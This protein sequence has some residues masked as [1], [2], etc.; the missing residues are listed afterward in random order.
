MKV[1]IQRNKSRRLIFFFCYL[2]IFWI[3][4]SYGDITSGWCTLEGLFGKWRNQVDGRR[5]K[6]ILGNF[7]L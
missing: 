5:L 2:R 7:D 4:C 1:K 6:G 3:S